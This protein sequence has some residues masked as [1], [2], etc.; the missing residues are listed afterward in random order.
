MILSRLCLDRPIATSLVMF[1]ILLV[2]MIAYPLL[3]I[4]SLPE[5]DYPTLQVSTFY[6]GANPDV[7]AS[8]VTAPLERQLGQIP[9][10][11]QMTSSSSFGLSLITLQFNLDI[12]L[13]VAEQEVQAAINAASG[14]LP[15]GLPN[16]PVYNKVNPAELPIIT[17]GLTSPTIPLPQ[18]EDFAETRLAQKISQLTGVGAVKVMGGR[19]AVRIQVN[20]TALAAYG[21]SPETLRSAINSANVN[22]AKGSL[23]GPRLAY[24]LYANDQLLSSDDYRALIVAYQHNAPVRLSDV[25][26][27]VDE[28]EDNRQMAWQNNTPAVILT[29]QRQPGANVIQVAD[30][31]KQLLEQIKPT[32]P[33][34]IQVT[35]LADR[36]ETVRASVSDLKGELCL[37]VALV[38][39]VI[40]VFLRNVSATFIPSIAVPLSLVGTL[41]ALY[42]LGFSL[43]NLTLMALTIAAGFV[44]DDAIVMTENISRYLEAGESPW[45]A[46]QK[47]AQQI[48]FTILS[49]TAAL[50]AV[51][52]PLLLMGEVIG[53]LFREFAMTV[54]VTILISA[55]VSLTLTP[56]LCS[57]LLRP[58]KTEKTLPEW[59]K[60]YAASLTWVLNRQG[61][62]LGGVAATLVLTGILLMTMPK[63]FFPEQ[64]TGFIQ[65]I[66]EAAPSISFQAMADRQKALTQILLADPA[67]ESV[68]SFVGIDGVNTLLNNGRLLIKLKPLAE[69]KSSAQAVIDRLESKLS[70]ASGI[71]LFL[72]SIQDLT[73]DN[74]IGR[75]AYQYSLTSLEPEV[76]SHWTDL[77]LTTLAKQP[78]FEEVASD[79]QTGGLQTWIE[80]DREKAARLGISAQLLDD[81]LYDLFGQRQISTLF[82]QRN[83]YHVVLE[84]APHLQKSATAL[85]Q[86]YFP[87]A[88][89]KPIPLTAFSQ[90]SQ[91]AGPLVLH[92]QDQFPVTTVSFNLAEGM[93]LSD[94][95]EAIERVKALLH[96][97]HSIQ[98]QFEGTAAIFERSLS[99]EGWLILAAVLAV[100]I[101][102]G[103]LY[104]SYIHPLTI[105]ST[106]PSACMGALL[107]LHFLGQELNVI[108][109]VALL[110]LVGIVMKNAILMIDF[111][112]EQ[113]RLYG[114]SP[115]EAIYEA[116]VLRCRPILMTTVASLFGAVPL[117][118]SG[119]MGSELRQPLGVAIIS[120]LIV[121]QLLTLY[122]TPVVYLS[123]DKLKRYLKL[124]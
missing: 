121:S 80:M 89:G 87:S 113:E 39:G 9:G 70:A 108:V 106:L 20:P 122:T 41:A 23:D 52:I 54:C 34:G 84:A 74:Q 19:P 38:I 62:V 78:E 118:F 43:N 75:F 3:P 46:A 102:L 6:P 94:A 67:V 61:W 55:F 47:G 14:G 53:R 32:L 57:R 63:G 50:I 11:D 93:A 101:V 85:E 22:A 96:F 51:F 98:T 13:D 65:G 28:R 31:V 60:R 35:V 76:L 92:R 5:V 49:L 27:V 26:T 81:T 116:A 103:V 40:F 90:I 25:A 82:T 7:I 83:Q 15:K 48:G 104:E 105:L 88:Q 124:H 1:A 95:V 42:G 107:V 79:Q 21:L 58:L 17:L 72:S 18:V 119:G 8:S 68:A 115:R 73:L 97:P 16:P 120:G 12:S 45:M 56:M 117:A 112:L 37:S 24:T 114:K 59:I 99:H 36:T 100:Y 4:S 2:G 64:D 69:R 123:F 111:A 30:R 91:K 44:V 110:L 71:R 86:V 10:L 29:I 77:F 109:L 33:N 66:S